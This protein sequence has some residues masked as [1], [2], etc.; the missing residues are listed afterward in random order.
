MYE[1]VRGRVTGYLLRGRIHVECR[2]I[3]ELRWFKC[4]RG[5]SAL[6]TL[7]GRRVVQSWSTIAPISIHL[8]MLTPVGISLYVW[9][10]PRCAWVLLRYLSS[11]LIKLYARSRRVIISCN[12]WGVFP[13]ETLKGSFLRRAVSIIQSSLGIT[14]CW[15]LSTFL[16]QFPRQL[17]AWFNVLHL[18]VEFGCQT[19]VVDNQWHNITGKHPSKRLQPL[20]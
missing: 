14:W 3:C 17:Q 10:V 9:Q 8:S 6:C 16:N 7:F 5:N 11:E 12:L 4:Q 15:G 2:T 19:W 20:S 1:L 18:L 13:C